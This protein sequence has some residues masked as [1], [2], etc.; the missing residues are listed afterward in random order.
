MVTV[1]SIIKAQVG[2]LSYFLGKKI[3]TSFNYC[4]QLMVNIP[5]YVLHFMG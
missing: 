5:V 3:Q 2:N 1:P 4:L